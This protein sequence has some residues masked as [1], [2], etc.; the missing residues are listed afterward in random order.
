MADIDLALKFLCLDRVHE[1]NAA[2]PRHFHLRPRDDYR[3]PRFRG[4]HQ[5]F[6]AASRTFV[7]GQAERAAQSRIHAGPVARQTT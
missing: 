3:G 6:D 7:F 1:G 2:R 5:T 4:G